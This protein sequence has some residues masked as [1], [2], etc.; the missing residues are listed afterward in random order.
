MLM[1]EADNKDECSHE[2]SN[3][4]YEKVSGTLNSMHNEL[5]GFRDNLR[6][7]EDN[8]SQRLEDTRDAIQ[9]IS[10]FLRDEPTTEPK[11]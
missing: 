9:A 4:E 10:S 5:A 2:A 6:M 11:R 3:S 7:Q 1:R 8:L